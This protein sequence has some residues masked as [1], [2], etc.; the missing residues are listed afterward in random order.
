ML[1]YLILATAT[2]AFFVAENLI[3][4]LSKKLKYVLKGV[5]DE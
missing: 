2:G 1:Y 4:C 5:G 3:K